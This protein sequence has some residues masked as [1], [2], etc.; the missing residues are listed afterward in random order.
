ML[1]EVKP[2]LCDVQVDP[3]HLA[4]ANCQHILGVDQICRVLKRQWSRRRRGDV[5]LAGGADAFFFLPNSRHFGTH[6]DAV[7]TTEWAEIEKLSK[8]GRAL[9]ERA[10]LPNP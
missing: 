10:R 4:H 9:K 3:L 8:W 6:R 1:T 2:E 5:R 7:P